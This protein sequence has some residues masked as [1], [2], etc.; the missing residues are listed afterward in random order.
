MA[1]PTIGPSDIDVAGQIQYVHRAQALV[2]VI[3]QINSLG[4]A[5]G[6]ATDGIYG[7]G[8]IAGVK[9]VQGFFGLSQDGITGQA[10]WHALVAG[11]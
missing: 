8:T 3:G 1:L 7:P 5:A 10:T 4:S 9:Q 2:K 6:I 11:S